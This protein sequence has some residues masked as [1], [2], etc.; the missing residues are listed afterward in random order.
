LVN[1]Q[2]KDY[3]WVK[4]PVTIDRGRTTEVHLDGNWNLPADVPKTK[5]VNVP[6]GNPVGWRAECTQAMEVD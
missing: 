3:S 5:L 1:A 2:A 4:V 6:N